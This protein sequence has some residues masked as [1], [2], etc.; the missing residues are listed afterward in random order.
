MNFP[1]QLVI[2]FD[3]EPEVGELVYQGDNGWYPQVAL[4]RRFAFTDL[5]ETE[6]MAKIEQFVSR[7]SPFLIEFGRRVKPD[8]MPVE[9]IEV[10]PAK[11]ARAFHQE[12]ITCMGS[13]IVSK[14]PEREGL[15]FYPHMTVTWDGLIVVREGLYEGQKREATYVWVLKD[16]AGDSRAYQKYKL[17]SYIA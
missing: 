5:G 8:H 15:N 9:V 3:R 16:Y 13:T 7:Q 11:S 6:G 4:K 2:F 10:A 1:Y 14:F 12:F 17:G